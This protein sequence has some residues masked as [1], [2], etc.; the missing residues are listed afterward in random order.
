MI[1]RA[2]IEVRDTCLEEN[3]AELGFCIASDRWGQGLGYEVCSEI[4]R[5][6]REE[7][8]LNSLIARC[9]PDNKASRRLLEKLGFEFICFQ[10]DGDCRYRLGL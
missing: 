1:G 5:L 7:Y 3:Q 2:G 10:D 9:D 8:D 6:A 4:V